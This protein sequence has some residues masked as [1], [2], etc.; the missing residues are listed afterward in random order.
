[1][2]HKIIKVPMGKCN[3]YLIATEKG[4]I[5]VDAGMPDKINKVKQILKEEK[6]TLSHIN[7]IIITHVHYDHVGCLK[8]L[9]EQSNAQVLVH[10]SEADLLIRGST[11]M[12]KGTNSIAKILS[13]ISNKFFPN[14]SKFEPVLPDISI[15]DEYDLAP[16][17]VDGKILHTPGHT[18]GS[19]SVILAEGDC[20]VGDTMFNLF[21]NT[22]FPVFANDTKELK[23]SWEKIKE[24]DCQRFHPGHGSSFECKKFIKSIN[25]YET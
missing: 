6:A 4:F 15:K 7:L 25:K 21:P 24:Y 19:I 20:L 16:F 11:N 12:P 9:K 3:S 14:F 2:S 17:G 22:V 13:K 10:K 18:K 23:Q 5:M 8:E 1:M